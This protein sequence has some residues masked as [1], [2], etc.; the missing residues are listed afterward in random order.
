M[1]KGQISK[2]IECVDK[3]VIE[4]HRI[5]KDGRVIEDPGEV[6]ERV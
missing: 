4:R 5:N 3:G 2:D 6:S 1:K